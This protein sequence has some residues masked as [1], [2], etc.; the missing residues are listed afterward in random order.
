MFG[1]SLRL[2]SKLVLESLSAH[3][4]LLLVKSASLV[5]VTDAEI[6]NFTRKNHEPRTD[7]EGKDKHNW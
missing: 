1:A 3:L 6:D 7:I 5:R 2:A 4:S